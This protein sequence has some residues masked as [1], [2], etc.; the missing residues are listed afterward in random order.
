M[1][2]KTHKKFVSQKKKTYKYFFNM[3]SMY[4]V[5]SIKPKKSCIYI[6]IH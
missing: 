2:K 1:F 4:I 6:Y 3:M 5:T